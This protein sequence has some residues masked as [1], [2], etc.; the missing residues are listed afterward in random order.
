MTIRG[1]R[2]NTGEIVLTQVDSRGTNTV[3]LKDPAQMV[4]QEIEPGRA[5]VALQAFLPY[6]SNITLYETSITAE[7]D[8]DQQVAN[9]YNRLFGTGIQIVGAD[10]LRGFQM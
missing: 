2:L 10:A 5:G 9:E 6:G 4:M 1:F 8:V 7:F 3:V